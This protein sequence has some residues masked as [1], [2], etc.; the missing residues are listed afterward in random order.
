MKQP[1]TI[2]FNN[3]LVLIDLKDAQST[4]HLKKI[5]SFTLECLILF[6]VMS[7]FSYVFSCCK[8]TFYASWVQIS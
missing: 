5:H 3:G 2:K 7:I 1:W 8:L 6:I 4:V